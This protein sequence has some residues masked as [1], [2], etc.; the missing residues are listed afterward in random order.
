MSKAP[1]RTPFT[2]LRNSVAGAVSGT[3]GANRR[4]PSIARTVFAFAVAAAALLAAPPGARAQTHEQLG[5]LERE[6]VDEALAARGL[7]PDPAPQGKPIGAIHVVTLEVFSQRDLFFDWFNIF[8]R[9]TREEMIRREALFR[10][11]EPYDQ[12]IIDETIRYLQSPDL[13]S[14]V[15]ILPVKSPTEGKVD[16]LI[17]TRDVWSLRFNT[18]FEY[19]QGDLIY[20]TTSLSE[21]N[22]FGWRKSVALVL[23]MDQ[24]AIAVG[25]TYVDRNIAGT[26][27]R[28]STQLRALFSRDEREAEGSSSSTTLT[29]PLYA[30][31]S[32]WG[33]SASFGH[34][35]GVA[36]VFQGNQLR[37]V[38]IMGQDLPWKYRVQQL[39]ASTSVSHQVRSARAVHR[40]GLGYGVATVR[41]SFTSDFPPDTV[42]PDPMTPSLREQ[43]A[44]E[45][46][47]LSQRVAAVSMDYGVSTPVWVTYR[48]L[49]TFDL[50]EDR[51]VGPSAGASVSRAADIIGSDV[52]YV[53]VGGSAGWTLT[54]GGGL[55]AI[56][57]GWGA[58]IQSGEVT[59]QVFSG[60]AY[61]A[62][63]VIKRVL[64][65]VASAGAT[66]RVD[67][68]QRYSYVLGGAN[69]L[70]GYAVG[71]F[72]TARTLVDK[73]SAIAHLEAR[74]MAFKVLS[75]RLGGLLFYDVG[76][77]STP[78]TP[79]GTPAARAIDALKSIALFHDFGFGLRL[80][81]PQ[82]NAY[83]IRFDWAFATQ[84]TDLTRAG[85]PGRISLGF[86][87]IF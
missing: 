3:P 42:P 61:V 68:T 24:G 49:D 75:L 58:R 15:A 44:L 87:Q 79:V 27:L 71:D 59:D 63:P 82:F 72:F 53:G 1:L 48:D 70:R 12:T 67:D 43:F 46:F 74:S 76:G 41:P 7:L 11:G 64:R 47:P 85:W 39:S 34:S 50:R 32:R 84:N 28:L 60:S 73:A 31:A 80:L 16:V 69:G 17:V 55:Q 36:R 52:T 20:L 66:A 9:T 6:S 86:S 22:L 13:T 78:T 37:T 38:T 51:Q 25:P 21:N 26:R 14:T 5:T 35:D 45:V 23:D 2:L 10:P 57:A 81:I 8:H 30:L 56:S 18:N 65:L 83:V 62:S 19:Q 40:V 29:Y 4:R 77:V 33:G 54:L